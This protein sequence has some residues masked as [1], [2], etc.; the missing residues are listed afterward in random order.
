M[1]RRAICAAF[2]LAD[3]R[4]SSYRLCVRGDIDSCVFARSLKRGVS[5]GRGVV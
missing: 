3:A 2:L 5:D 1:R 4:I